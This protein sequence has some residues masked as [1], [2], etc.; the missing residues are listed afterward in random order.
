MIAFPLGVSRQAMLASALASGCPFR[1][2][3]PPCRLPQWQHGGEGSWR[4]ASPFLDALVLEADAGDDD[5]ALGPLEVV[6]AELPCLGWETVELLVLLV[7]RPNCKPNSFR[8]AS[9]ALV[10]DKIRSPIS[11]MLISSPCDIVS[12][13]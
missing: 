3:S 9:R 12:L 4:F 2:H 11:S 6:A 7:T 8:L 10:K 13:N 5:D 1:L